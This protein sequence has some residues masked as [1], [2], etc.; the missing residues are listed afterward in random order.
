MFGNALRQCPVNDGSRT[1]CRIEFCHSEK[2]IVRN[3]LLKSFIRR[4]KRLSQHF[5]NKLNCWS[6]A[7]SGYI[8]GLVKVKHRSC[9]KWLCGSSWLRSDDD[10]TAG[11]LLIGL[12]RLLEMNNYT[13]QR[14]LCVFL[15][16]KFWHFPSTLSFAK[17]SRSGP[18]ILRRS[19]QNCKNVFLEMLSFHP[20]ILPVHISKH[21]NVDCSIGPI[22]CIPSPSERLT[23]ICLLYVFVFE[24]RRND[25]VLLY[26][27]VFNWSRHASL[28]SIFIILMVSF[29]VSILRN[30]DVHFTCHVALCNVCSHTCL[31]RRWLNI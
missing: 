7:L 16:W 5:R 26:K 8:L 20:T 13:K 10:A 14:Y 31:G 2:R 17:I 1:N 30:I 4:W 23:I 18:L 19:A 24:E 25:N 6:Y 15:Q 11:K 9:E 12:R 29:V 22:V 3:Q 27:P 28:W 21:A